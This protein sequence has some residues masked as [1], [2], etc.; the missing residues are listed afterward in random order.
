[1]EETIDFTLAGVDASAFNGLSVI[2][3]LYEFCFVEAR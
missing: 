2:V 1:M 3:S